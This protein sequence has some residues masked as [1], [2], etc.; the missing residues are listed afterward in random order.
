LVWLCLAT[1]AILFA[2]ACAGPRLNGGVRSEPLDVSAV[3]LPD[4]STNNVAMPMRA[5]PGELL[6][7]YFGYTS[8]P[9]ICPTTMSDLGQAIRRLPATEAGRVDVAMVTLDPERDTGERLGQYLDHF[10]ERSHALRTTSQDELQAAAN[11]FGVRWEVE[12]HQPGEAY[13]ISHTAI[14]YAVDAEGKVLVEWPFGM[15]YE[16][17]RSD[18]SVL[19]ARVST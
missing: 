16:L 3:S 18:L 10:F 9:D 14:T 17:I 1:A 11:A 13:S 5:Q 19:L 15:D 8:C 12:A 7:V 2:P 4:A 6:L